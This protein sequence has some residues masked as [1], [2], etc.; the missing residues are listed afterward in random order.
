MDT[1]T[2]VYSKIT[3]QS[4]IRSCICG[5]TI[6]S[7]SAMATTRLYMQQYSYGS[8]FLD[9]WQLGVLRP[10]LFIGGPKLLQ[11]ERG[12]GRSLAWTKTLHD[13]FELREAYVG[14]KGGSIL[15]FPLSGQRET[16]SSEKRRVSG[17]KF[18]TLY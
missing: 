3:S 13:L 2:T 11:F 4:P 16:N 6:N 14:S 9:S 18:V 15:T 1:Q 8:Y 5:H 12:R 17:W 7:V 10:D